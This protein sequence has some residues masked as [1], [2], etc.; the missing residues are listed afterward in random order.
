MAKK[1]NNLLLLGLGGLI[2]YVLTRRPSY[3]PPP[4]QQG[5]NYYPSFPQ[6]PPAPQN[7]AAAFQAWASAILS[8]FGNVASLWEPGGPFYQEAGTPGS[9]MIDVNTL[10]NNWE[11]W[12]NLV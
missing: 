10:G 4:I 1:N 12:E 7:N 8:T 11:E 5:Y 2:L 6:V 9:E 3:T